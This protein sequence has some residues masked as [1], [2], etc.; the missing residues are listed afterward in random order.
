MDNI[1]RVVPVLPALTAT[2]ILEHVS[3]EDIFSHYFLY[4]VSEIN[5][6]ART[7][8]LIKSRIRADSSPS[9]GFR[10]S[11]NRL[12]CRDFGGYFWGDCFDAAAL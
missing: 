8:S 12:K 3:Q 10:Y 11:R 7:N 4:S 1:D 5:K 6:C 2:Y 9:V